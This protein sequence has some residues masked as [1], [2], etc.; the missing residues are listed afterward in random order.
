MNESETRAELIDPKLK[1]SGWGEIEETKIH[2]EFH[3]TTGRIQTDGTRAKPEIADYILS[4]KNQKLAA[5]EAKSAE[6]SYSEGV[7]QAKDYASKLKLDYTY[8]SNGKEVYEIC[9]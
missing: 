7:Q 6:V 4:Y 3:I 8:S 5:V 1:Q 9:L 2:R